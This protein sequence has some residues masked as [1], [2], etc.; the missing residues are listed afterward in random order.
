MNDEQLRPLRE[1][2]REGDPAQGQ[3]GLTPDEVREMRRAVL[4]AIP[5]TRRRLLPVLVLVGAAAAAVLIAVLALRSGSQVPSA[6]SRTAA[7]P[8][9]APRGPEVVLQPPVL[10]GES[11]LQ[12]TAP[13]K[14]QHPRRHPHPTATPMNDTLAALEPSARRETTPIREIQFSTPG[15]TRII[16]TLAPDKTS[17]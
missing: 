13:K 6:P 2:L 14:V 17:Y 12:E 4:N 15:G 1:R 5:E 8:R 3:E 7:I 9:T 16:W 11:P 10:T